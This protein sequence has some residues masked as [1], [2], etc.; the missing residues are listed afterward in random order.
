L[1]LLQRELRARDVF[2]TNAA[3]LGT[4]T[5]LTMSK[6]ISGTL[7]SFSDMALIACAGMAAGSV[8][9]LILAADLLRWSRHGSLTLGMVLRFS[10]PQAL[11]MAM[12]TSIRQLD[13]FLVQL[14]Y[15]T[16][17]VG[18]YNAAK[19]LYRVFETGADAAVWL[20]YPTAVRLLHEQRQQALQSIIGKALVLQIAVALA[21]VGILEL[22]GTSVLV[23]FLGS[24][25]AE[26]TAMFNV[27]AVG[28]VFLPFVMLQSVHL[29]LHRVERLLSIT[30]IGVGAAMV[31]Y[32]VV[33]RFGP[34]WLIGIGVVVY[35]AVVALLLWYPLRR[36]GI[37]EPGTIG[38][39]FA[40]IRAGL[41]A[42]A[43]R[44]RIIPRSDEHAS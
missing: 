19:M 14:F 1:K 15:S 44:I 7:H 29:A 25:Y 11:M 10:S 5:L 35:A 40:E 37:I 27:M 39:A 23:G 42:M 26:T 24:R 41:V 28:A 34:D 2:L 21:C 6:L 18:I 8:V 9:G 43:S 16:R 31:S 36:D 4:S 17:T 22:G 30:A 13:I 3:W 12:A 32:V 33:G 38:R 20:M